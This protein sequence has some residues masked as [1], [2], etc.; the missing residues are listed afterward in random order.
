MT[1]TGVEAY[2]LW[3]V[4]T[5]HVMTGF[6]SEPGMVF[7][8]KKKFDSLPASARKILVDNSGEA[9][10]RKFGAYWDSRKATAREI[11][12]KEGGGDKQIMVEA[13]PAQAAAWA[14]V[15]EPV[16]EEWGK[17]TPGGDKALATYRTLLAA[18][19]AGK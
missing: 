7:M 4:T 17:A 6:G 12:K 1:W 10:S 18:V 13:T 14:K 16:A 8:A 15:L 3:E 9:M 11:A 2:K 19:K 5:Y